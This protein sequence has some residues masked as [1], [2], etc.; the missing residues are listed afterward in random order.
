MIAEY[1]QIGSRPEAEVRRI[2][3][4]PA[5]DEPIM[6][7]VLPVMGDFDGDLDID[8][9]DLHSMAAHWLAAT[10]Q[11]GYDVKY[12]LNG[13]GVINYD[14]TD[15]LNYVNVLLGSYYYHRDGLGSIAAISDE[16]GNTVERYNYDV[17]GRVYIVNTDGTPLEGSLIGNPYYFTGRMLDSETGL[18]YYRARMYSPA[19]GRFLQT[20]PIGYADGMN[21]YAYCGNN[22]V[23]LLDPSG[24]CSST[25]YESLMNKWKS[26]DAE[27]Q[28]LASEGFYPVPRSSVAPSAWELRTAF[29]QDSGYTAG[30]AGGLVGLMN[31][32]GTNL[33]MDA[34]AGID[35]DTGRILDPGEQVVAGIIGTGNAG[36]RTTAAVSMV[37]SI[38]E[39][40]T[41]APVQEKIHGNS[42][43]STNLNYGYKLADKNTGAVLKYG[44]TAYPATRYSQT[45]LNKNNAEMLVEVQ[46]PKLEIHN[47]QHQQILNYKVQNGVRP[48]LN[49]S[50]W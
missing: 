45:F 23:I 31:L 29:L 43:Q 49:K 11:G 4:G 46:G 9:D 33:W 26:A 48:P 6:I 34:V 24:L 19:L 27:L 36:L 35:I 15:I 2:V 47:W 32:S 10:G 28:R 13:D 37:G 50:D 42:L 12:D 30:Q 40:S 41:P 25:N 38:L 22:P 20:D 17:F 5:I 8:T 16:N 3:Y 21:W 39:S 44:E 14:D 18:Y 7:T 1:R